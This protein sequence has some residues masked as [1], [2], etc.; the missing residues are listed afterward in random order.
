MLDPSTLIQLETLIGDGLTCPANIEGLNS[1]IELKN[2]LTKQLNN[3]YNKIDSINKF[4]DP[5]DSLISTTKGGVTAAQIG[6]DALQFIPSTVATPIPVAP[7]I[8]GQKVINKL[9]KLIN[10]TEGQIGTGV[11][12]LNTVKSNL[13]R[14]LDLLALVDLFIG[15]CSEELSKDSTTRVQ[16]QTKISDQLLSS[17]QEQ[18]K[19]LSPVVTNANGFQMEVISVDNVTIQGLKRRRAVARNKAGIIMLQG[20]PSFSSN[21]QILIDELVFYIKQN[22]LKAE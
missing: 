10:K 5:L 9:N 2:K 22:D 18:S 16:E 19:Q 3:I 17:T 1:V 4:L 8:S 21:D 6:I 11:G 13:E 20:E 14:I 12:Y 7:I 15:K